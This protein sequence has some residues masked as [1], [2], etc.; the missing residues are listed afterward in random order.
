MSSKRSLVHPKFK[1][2]YRVA[3]WSDYDRA[4]VQRG[5]ITL[6]LSPDA[7]ATWNAKP[8]R[9]RGGQRKY[10][11]VAIET[12]LT[13]RL[14]LHLPLRQTEGF[15]R[16]IFDLMNLSLDVPDHTTIS[17]RSARLHVPLTFRPGTGAIDLVV[18]SSGLS[19]FRE[20]QWAAVKHGGK[21]IQGWRKLHLGVD[22]TGML[23]DN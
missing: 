17:R 2:K 21:G 23:S 16:S 15:L 13:L 14:L 4:L 10:S 8:T 22:E 1:T 5:N 12:A 20:G 3:N 9:R 7:A 19:I 6:W 18:D 11:D